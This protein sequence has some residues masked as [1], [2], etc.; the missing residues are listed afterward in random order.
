MDSLSPFLE[1]SPSLGLFALLIL[2]GIGL[3]FPED[4][5]LILCGFLI[6]SRIAPPL[7][8]LVAVYAG[9]LAADAILYSFGRRYGRAI[10]THKRFNKI[11]SPERLT[12]YEDIF[13]RRGVLFILFGRHLM[14]LRVHVFLVA[15]IM[16]MPFAQFIMAD[17][18]SASF[19]I[20][21]MTGLGYLGGSSL[22]IIMRDVNRIEHIAVVLAVIIATAALIIMYFRSRR[23]RAG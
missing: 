3:P 7:P 21:V 2:G 16:K 1:H 10:L 22:G 12:K 18:I 6:A 14:G 13:A 20:L 11:L 19:T 17:A 8:A 5:T 4:A 23:Y 9:L 15:G